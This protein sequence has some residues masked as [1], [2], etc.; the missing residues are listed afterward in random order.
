[1]NKNAGLVIPVLAL[2]VTGAVFSLT[3][4]GVTLYKNFTGTTVLGDKITP[5]P[6]HRG[7]M[8]DGVRVY[9]RKMPSG[10]TTPVLVEGKLTKG[11]TPDKITV[12]LVSQDA[13]VAEFP[14]GV[15]AVPTVVLVDELGNKFPASVKCLDFVGRKVADDV[16]V[17]VDAA[18]SDSTRSDL[19]AFKSYAMGKPMIPAKDE[20]IGK[21]PNTGLLK[22]GVTPK[23][24]FEEELRRPLSK[25]GLKPYLYFQCDVIYPKVPVATDKVEVM[26]RNLGA[27]CEKPTGCMDVN[28]EV[29]GQKTRHDTNGAPELKKY[30]T[31][32]TFTK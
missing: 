31:K 9:P 15:K 24:D 2:V 14:S 32:S 23:T 11:F 30:N 27:L 19:R 1:M 4:I 7:V 12:R 18:D 13:A 16:Y 8:T 22:A 20:A 3:L 28:V 5:Q 26:V 17:K 25:L 6:V 29:T 10:E 21:L